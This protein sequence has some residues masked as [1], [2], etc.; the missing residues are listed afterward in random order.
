MNVVLGSM[1]EHKLA[2]MRRACGLMGWDAEVVAVASD[3]QVSAQPVGL[4]ETLLGAQNRAYG[5][6]REARDSVAVGIES[7]VIR[8]NGFDMQVDIDL[9]VIVVVMPNG[10]S[11][12]ST[13]SGMQFP[14]RFLSRI[15]AEGL[16]NTTAGSLISE[17]LGGDGT[18]PHEVLT[19]GRLIRSKMLT[20]G[21]IAA[22]AQVPTS[23][24]EAL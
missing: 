9:A 3:S 5:V 10:S 22:L 21:I 13:S 1:S 14:S 12:V 11:Y 23:V 18:N 4:E 19:E 17:E 8:I 2:A 6:R 15:L 7:G 20:Q 16:E 24:L